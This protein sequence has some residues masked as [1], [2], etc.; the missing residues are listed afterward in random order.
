MVG[1]GLA[2]VVGDCDCDGEGVGSA[3]N[4]L[5][6]GT[7]TNASEAATKARVRNRIT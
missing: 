6:F 5:M 1:V 7:S 4:E 2:V 3:A